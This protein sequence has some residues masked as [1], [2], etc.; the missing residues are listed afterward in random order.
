MYLLLCCSV[1][2]VS[3]KPPASTLLVFHT[4][5]SSNLQWNMLLPWI[6]LPV[7]HLNG[8]MGNHVP[9]IEK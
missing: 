9:K 3:S 6:F 5:K 2:I 1:G 8:F 4:F 7:A